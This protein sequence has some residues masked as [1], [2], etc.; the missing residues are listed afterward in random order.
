MAHEPVRV[1]AG[2]DDGADVRVAV[3]PVHQRVELVGDVAA[4]QLVRATVDPDDQHGAAVLDLK[5]ALQ[6]LAHGSRLP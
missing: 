5:V 1:G 4:E 3:G 6:V 2:Q